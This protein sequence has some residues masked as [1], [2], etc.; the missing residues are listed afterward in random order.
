MWILQICTPFALHLKDTQLSASRRSSDPINIEIYYL[1]CLCTQI[2]LH[3]P[4]N[5]TLGFWVVRPKL[6][7]GTLIGTIRGESTQTGTRTRTSQWWFPTKPSNNCKLLPKRRPAILI[8]FLGNRNT[9]LSNLS[10]CPLRQPKQRG[11]NKRLNATSQTIGHVLTRHLRAYRSSIVLP[12][13]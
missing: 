3:V 9:T 8:A 7:T 12:E 1:N 10:R 4:S 6:R 5:L 2:K 11:L 13:I